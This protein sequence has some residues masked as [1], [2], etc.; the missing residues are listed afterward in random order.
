MVNFVVFICPKSHM[1]LWVT[2]PHGVGIINQV[3]ITQSP[4]LTHGLTT[5]NYLNPKDMITNVMET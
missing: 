5:I 1:V 3:R 2:K 4:I